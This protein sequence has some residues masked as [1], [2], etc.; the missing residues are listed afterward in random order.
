[1]EN[2]RQFIRRVAG[3][4]SGISVLSGLFPPALRSLFGAGSMGRDNQGNMSSGPGN[5]RKTQVTPLKSFEVMGKTDIEVNLD[6]WRLKIEDKYGAIFEYSYNEILKLPPVERKIILVCPGFFENHG[7]WKGFS[8]GK[9]I[10]R[11]GLDKG[12]E[13]VFISGLNGK[14]EKKAKFS[15][16]SVLNDHVFLA[17]EVNRETLPVRNG[18]PLRAVAENKMGSYWIKY[19]NKITLV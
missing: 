4:F 1:M 15:I 14:K 9:I 13:K 12:V 18:F 10:K 2:R 6:Q 16:D 11:L 5:P 19:V 7:F 17:Y 8:P 3:I